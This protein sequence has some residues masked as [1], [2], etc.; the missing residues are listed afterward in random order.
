LKDG[1]VT[2]ILRG[3]Q[4]SSLFTAQSGL[5]IDFTMNGFNLR[6]TRQHAAARRE[7]VV[8]PAWREGRDPLPT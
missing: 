6:L 1:T 7:A 5:P 3:W 4:V 2:H 8:V